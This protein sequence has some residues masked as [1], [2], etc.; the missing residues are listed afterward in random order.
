[1]RVAFATF[2][3]QEGRPFDSTGSSRIRARWLCKYWDEAEEYVNG[4]QYDN[5]IYQKV[6]WPEHARIFKGKKILDL[7]DPDWL[8]FGYRVKE[9]I[10]EVDAITTSTEA[11]AKA[12]EKFSGGK[13]VYY[14][15]DRLDLE[16]HSQK[17]VHLGKAKTV[18]WFGYSTG[19]D[20]LSSALLSIEKLKLDLIVISNKTFTIPINLKDSVSLINYPWNINTV[21][22]DLLKADIVLNPRSSKGR[23][24][25]KSNNKTITAWALGLPVA[26]NADELESFVEESDR[27][28]EA[29]LRLIEVKDKYDVKE[30]VKQYKEIFG[31][32]N[33]N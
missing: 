19:F 25:F 21:N 22:D 16:E 4:R 6:Y 33:K 15:P 28:K 14:I 30:S 24:V 1:M 8:H 31:K 9:M 23:Y 27:K 10:E 5:I 11:L 3:K 20:L 32:I 12:V 2:E 18:A 26:H 13:P 17:K 7:C 29:E